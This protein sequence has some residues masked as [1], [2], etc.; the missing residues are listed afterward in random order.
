ML[1]HAKRERVKDENSRLD[2]DFFAVARV[3]AAADSSENWN[4]NGRKLFH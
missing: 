1:L 2:W 4:E 3:T